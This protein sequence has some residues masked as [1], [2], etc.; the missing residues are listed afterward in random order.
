MSTYKIAI[1]YFSGTQV[2][3]AY[4]EVIQQTLADKEAETQLLDVTSYTSRQKDFALDRYTGVVFGFP[5]YSD[6]APS[7]INEWIPT[8]K[9]QGTPCAM[10][11]TY[12]A[13]TTG[14]AHF[15]TKTLLE[16]AGFRVRFSAEFLGRHTFNFGGW[17]VLPNRPDEEDFAVAR[18][19][20]DLALERFV[21]VSD[22]DFTLQKPFGYND[23]CALKGQKKGQRPELG[24]YHPSRASKT[25]RMCRKC[26]DECPNQAFNA[27][28]GQSDPARCILCLRCAYSC[29][30][31]V[32]TLGAQVK[33]NY[34]HFL[35]DWHLTDKIVNAK[36]SKLITSAGQAAY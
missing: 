29:P 21:Q 3:K 4:A 24:P 33:A 18:E 16:Q 14:Y 2:T 8:L 13:R 35:K 17:Q 19:F 6:F 22:D 1:V 5:V 11:F 25:C 12:G 31:K 28:T 30:D 20:A 34:E 26:E 15:H 10:F 7:V 23:I 9:G 32:L 27:E 36:R